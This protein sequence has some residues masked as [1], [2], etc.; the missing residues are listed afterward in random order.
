MLTNLIEAYVT[1]LES[2]NCSPKT[3]AYHRQSL[4]KFGKWLAE[5]GN[6]ENPDDWH[7]VTIRFYFLWLKSSRKSDGSPLSPVSVRTYAGSLRSFCHWLAREE[8]CE[9][10]PMER[11]K[12]P[13]A[14]KM[15][16]PTLS[17]DD[18]SKLLK[19][20]KQTR[21]AW[22]DEAIILF[23]LDTGARANEVCQL[24]ESDV[25]W[26]E[27]LAKVYGKGAKERF[28][29]FSTATMRAMQ[30]YQIKAKNRNPQCAQF[31]QSEEGRALT[32]SGLLQLC[33]R[34]GSKAGVEGVHPH[35][36]R[37]TFAISF[38]RAGASVFA[39]Q[40]TLG[41]T[42]LEMTLKYSAMLTD[43]IKD[44]HEAS[45]PVAHLLGRRAAKR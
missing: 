38:L 4:S 44:A 29:P 10:N 18:C 21:N 33:E 27:R 8:L 23:M 1:H 39:L 26:S 40:K 7:A 28:V 45:S 31:F 42:S 41:H 15:V 32:P 14:P 2:E 9:K 30:R 6:S 25:I 37:H 35:R 17:P 36:L 19:A 11:V 16:K 13:S 22:R 34:L 20:A 12:M 43:D 5:S 3:L 24:A